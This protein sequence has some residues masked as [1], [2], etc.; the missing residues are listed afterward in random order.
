MSLFRDE[1]AINCNASK[2]QFTPQK[3]FIEPKEDKEY[4]VKIGLAV[5]CKKC[6][7]KFKEEK[8]INGLCEKCNNKKP[9]L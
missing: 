8:L 6:G 7:C 9:S 3:P 1:Y 4:T 5:R 2:S